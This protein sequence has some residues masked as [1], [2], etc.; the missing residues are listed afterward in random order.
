MGKL[1]KLKAIFFDLD[2]TLW[3]FERNSK[4]TF[5]DIFNDYTF[6]FDYLF[7]LEYYV[8]INHKYWD[9]Y[10]KNKIS[11]KEL[12]TIRFRETFDILKFNY[13]DHFLID[14]SNKYINLLPTK[15]KL[16]KGVKKM[17]KTLSSKYKLH[18]ITNGFDEVQQ[19]KI[20]L[21]GLSKYFGEIITSERAGKKKPNPKIFEYAL[22][23]THNS[24]ENC[25][26]IGDNFFADICGAKSVG[27]NTIHFNSNFEDYHDICP[28]IYS[29]KN[30]DEIINKL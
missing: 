26:M 5:K 25:L 7:F 28:I 14:I 3:D 10:S 15:N 8:P 22:N 29:Y 30:I 19:K 20:N 4:L 1:G 23:L 9:L 6:P 17:L 18:I 16:F 13:D 2:H 11:K 12:R 24:A 27:M 21:S